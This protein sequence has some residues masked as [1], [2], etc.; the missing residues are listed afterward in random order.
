MKKEYAV[1]KGYEIAKKFLNKK[2]CI[3]YCNLFSEKEKRKL[4]LAER[5]ITEDRIPWHFERVSK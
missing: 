5:I 2:E 1:F 4:L 3:D